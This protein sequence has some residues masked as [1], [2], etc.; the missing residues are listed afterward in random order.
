M[1]PASPAC[2]SVYFTLEWDSQTA[3]ATGAQATG[4]PVGGAGRL[5]AARGERLPGSWPPGPWA[6]LSAASSWPRGPRDLAVEG[7]DDCKIQV[8]VS[9][10]PPRASRGFP[11]RGGALCADGLS[12]GA[13][14]ASRS[15][16]PGGL[17]PSRAAPRTSYLTRRPTGALEVGFQS[18]C[19]PLENKPQ[20]GGGKPFK[21]QQGQQ[22]A[23]GGGFGQALG[24]P[25]G[26]QSPAGGRGSPWQCH[27]WGPRTTLLKPESQNLGWW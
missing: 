24:T 25:S 15:H 21:S 13:G 9:R 17:T 26:T 14:W 10:R 23:G 22:P 20:S 8:S 18:P 16:S 27:L 19:Y 12:A 5:A 6:P 3:A 4:T 1:L 11:Q 7:A 2:L